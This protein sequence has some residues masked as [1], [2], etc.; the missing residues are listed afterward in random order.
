VPQSWLLGHQPNSDYNLFKYGL[1]VGGFDVSNYLYSVGDDGFQWLIVNGTAY[2]SKMTLSEDGNLTVAN[3][4]YGTNNVYAGGGYGNDGVSLENNGNGWFNGMLTVDQD[5][6]IK[7]MSN[8]GDAGLNITNGQ[9][10]I[11]GNIDTAS[12]GNLL[13]L[14]KEGVDK[15]KVDN[16]GNLTVANNIYG[17]NNVYAGGNLYLPAEVNMYSNNYRFLY[18]S[19][20]NKNIT[21]GPRAGND[22]I[23]DGQN[24]TLVGNRSGRFITSGDKNTAVGSEVMMNSAAGVS[25]NTVLGYQAGYNLQNGNNTL[26]GYRAGTGLTTGNNNIIIGAN[27]NAPSPIAGNQLNIGN[28]I[29]GDLSN[30]RVGIGTSA[31]SAKLDVQGMSVFGSNSLN[32]INS[33]NLIYGNIDTASAGNLLLLQKEGVDKFKVDG[34]GNLYLPANVNFSDAG[35]A[36]INGN[37]SVQVRIDANNNGTNNF[38]IN[39]GAN[40]SIFRITEDGEI[41]NPIGAV[42][43]ISPL[44]VPL[45]ISGNSGTVSINDNLDVSNTV[46]MGYERVVHTCAGEYI[47]EC[48]ASCNPGTKVIGGGTNCPNNNVVASFPDSDSSWTGICNV[49]TEIV[50]YAICARIGD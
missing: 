29:Y 6:R 22:L 7:G 23:A 9:N 30:G 42:S 18:S 35:S 44:I 14:Q 46:F 5:F 37:A 20:D 34:N 36:Y 21:I 10:L 3:N 33:Q 50:T 26:I 28:I 32:V 13:L 25:N 31:P 47:N 11:Y 24:N 38:S 39:N 41:Y 15:L 19:T 12:A 17:T 2:T 8:L 48:I 16:N 49:S 4:I 1:G 43:I 40:Q 45:G 27:V